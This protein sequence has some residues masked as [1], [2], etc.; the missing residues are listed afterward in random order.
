MFYV[1]LTNHPLLLGLP[2]QV[3]QG[4]L[5]ET[6]LAIAEEALEGRP[7]FAEVAP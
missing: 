1:Q 2:E 5:E 4:I 3:D 6:A 7:G